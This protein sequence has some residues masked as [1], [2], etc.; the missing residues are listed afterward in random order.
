MIMK[1]LTIA[2]IATT[3]AMFLGAGLLHNVIFADFYAARAGGVHQANFAAPLGYLVLGLL[4]TLIFQFVFRGK[5]PVV[6]GLIFGATIG[7]L[8]VFPHELVTAGIHGDPLGY[9]FA[10]AAVHVVEQG[11]GGIVLGFVFGRF[12]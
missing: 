3:T 6:E 8:W 10:N 1:H 5:K 2:T 4:M 7:L 9:V 11:F 12:S